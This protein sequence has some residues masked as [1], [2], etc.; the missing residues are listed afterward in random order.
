MQAGFTLDDEP[1]IE[2]NPAV[3]NGV[4]LLEIFASPMPPGDLYR[5]VTVLTF[6]LNERLAPRG[7][8][9]YHA[10]NIMLHAGVTVLVFMLALRLFGIVQVAQIAA[11]LFALHPVHTEAVTSLV[12][13]AEL[14]AA[15]FGLA[16]I[17]SMDQ[18]DSTLPG[19][20]RVASHM[21]ALI[22]FMLALFSKESAVVILPLLLLFRIARRGESLAAGLPIELRSLDWLPF[23]LCTAVYLLFRFWTTGGMLVHSA[24]PL[25]NVLAFVPSSVR[26]RSALGVLWDYFGLLSFPL[27][28]SADYSY[29]EVP[30]VDSWTDPRFLAG[31]ALVVAAVCVAVRDR[32]PAVTFAVAFPFIALSLTSNVLFPIGTIKAERLLYLPSVG[33]ALLVAFSLDWLMR[34]PRYRLISIGLL[35][36]LIG[37]F[38]ARTWA[39]NWDW[40]DNATLYRSI[41]RSA[42]NSAKSHLNL[43]VLLQREKADAAAIG[44]YQRAL[45]I[46]PY[47][48]R[49]R[50]DPALGIG[51][52]FHNEGRLERAIYWY[53]KAL[54][55]APAF[56]DAHANLCETLLIMSRF[57][58]ACVA[59]RRG[60]RYEPADAN[61]LKLLGESLVGSGKVEEG[62]AVLHRSLALNDRDEELR[63]YLARLGACRSNGASAYGREP[64]R[65]TETTIDCCD[66][67]CGAR[68]SGSGTTEAFDHVQRWCVHRIMPRVDAAAPATA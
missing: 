2:R 44:H 22:C 62:S 30:I 19:P 5:P 27:I 18:A 7:A 55:I 64:G 50:V 67:L 59:C 26:I 34:V 8:F 65:T 51:N 58:E 10:A 63:D 68:R 25:D 15:L 23:A 66:A 61:L 48:N 20:A 35:P 36:I 47:A 41:A 11:V 12:G 45:E 53:K 3:Q 49:Q 9:A 60:L 46:Y 6:A 33:W 4:D 43:G 17:L 28:L 31:G 56:D 1:D 57:D 40:L 54:E 38:A 39:R 13:R 24:T 29:N 42:P 37:F 16:A 21:L 14:L 32:R 52:V